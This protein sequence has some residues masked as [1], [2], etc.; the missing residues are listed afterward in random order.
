MR[1]AFDVDV[2]H[3]TRM[4]GDHL[5]YSHSQYRTLVSLSLCTQ[6]LKLLDDQPVNWSGGHSMVDGICNVVGLHM[7][8]CDWPIRLNMGQQGIRGKST[9]ST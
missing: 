7:Q 9:L 1:W 2:L 6:L 5:A 4:Q 8:V 3:R